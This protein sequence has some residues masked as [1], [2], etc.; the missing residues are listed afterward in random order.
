MKTA[1]PKA[2]TLHVAQLNIPGL[3]QCMTEVVRRLVALCLLLGILSLLLPRAYGQTPTKRVLIVTGSD[4]NHVGFSTITRK[5][6]SILRSVSGS[7]VEVLYELQHGLVEPPESPTGDEELASYLR[8]KYANRKL[9][10]ILSLAAPRMRM[11]LQTDPAL[12]ESIPKVFYEFDSEREATN[13]SLG[14]NITGVWAHVDLNQT[15]LLALALH[16]DARKVVVVSGNGP[17]DD[18][19]RER[20]RVEFQKYEKRAEFSY[21]TGNTIE[22]L[23]G[24]LAALD[25]KSVVLFLMFTRD[26]TGNRFSGPEVI[27]MLAPSSGAPIYGYA[28]TLM[29]LGLTGGNLLDFEGIGGRIGEMSLRVLAGERPEKIAQETAPTA[30][31]LDWR[32]LQR[33][34]V[35]ERSLP[36]GSVV[37]F[38]QPS[39]WE[40]Y[41]WRIV[42]VILLCILESLLI[43]LLL[44]SRRRHRV[45]EGAKD[46]LAAIVESSDDAILSETLEGTITSWNAGAERTY[47][48]S[49]KEI[50]GQ[51]MMTLAPT[52][53]K[54]EVAAIL[55]K[56]G[57]GESVDHLE[58]TRVTKDGRRIDVSLTISPIRDEQ[59]KIVGS[60]TI[61]RDITDQKKAQAEA[62]EQQS[63][64]AHLSRVTILGELSG[65]IAHELNQPLAAI[66]INAQTAQRFLAHED[67]DLDE[68]REI[69]TD[70]VDQD[71]RAGEVIHRLR[72]LLK[73]GEVQQQA[74]DVNNA[75]QE[76]LKLIHGDLL[77]HGVTAL[78]RLGP[79]LPT[80]KGDRVQLQQVLLNLLMNACDAMNDNAAADRQIIVSTELSDSAHVRFSVSDCGLG[81]RAGELEKVFE[82][83]VSSKA[84]GLGLGLSVCRSIITA[85]D[86]KLWAANNPEK[87]VTFHFTLPVSEK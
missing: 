80:V 25:R 35:S 24:K 36:P 7:R 28:D 40:L 27:S 49:A 62:L 13:R 51:H 39:L 73:K 84:N 4:P 59:K 58:T 57:R 86:G 21:V 65:S 19:R 63:E 14:P 61:A 38:R 10:L 12:F 75:V 52:D 31:T 23:R 9:D 72:L 20:A 54:N 43:L 29:G 83:F 50:M 81:L 67:V 2:S 11:V 6:V 47:G 66:L 68:V 1:I 41:K 34:G 17:E 74:L 16:P 45:A 78:T 77:N 69:L 55:E 53:L 5:V 8:R 76:V 30:I 22:E 44:I 3:Q 15:L 82:P 56:I 37:R 87:G 26:R 32:E 18:Q 71:T 42:G 70:I 48:Y 60:S 46:K 33:W 85:H 64:L 79:A